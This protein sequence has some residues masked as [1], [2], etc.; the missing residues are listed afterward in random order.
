MYL[1]VVTRPDIAYYAM[2]LGHFSAKPTQSHMLTA[3]HV[4][5]YLGGTKLLALYLGA[6]SLTTPDSLH[7]YMQNMGC[8]DADWAS[9]ALDRKSISGYLFYSQGSLISWSAVKQKLIVLSSTEAKYYAMTHAF[10]EALWIW[11]FL[12]SLH[13]PVPCPFLVLSD[14]QVA[15]TL[16]HSPAISLCSKHINICHHFIH[17]HV[18][19]G[20]FTTIWILISD[21]PANIFTKPLNSSL[22]SCHRKVLGLSIPLS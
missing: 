22:F 12:G 11:V 2:W 5:C 13:L 19:D 7:G 4:L 20:S 6:P 15:C 17:A 21:M 18:Q 8:S 1:V 3:K 10:K 16:S 9:E 14:N